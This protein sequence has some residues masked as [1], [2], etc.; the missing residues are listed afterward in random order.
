MS[1]MVGSMFKLEGCGICEG[2]ASIR[3]AKVTFIVATLSL[4]AAFAASVSAF[5]FSAGV[6]AKLLWVE[7]KLLWVLL[8]L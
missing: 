3:A 4:L 5:S 8:W 6:A 2:F 7:N 1:S